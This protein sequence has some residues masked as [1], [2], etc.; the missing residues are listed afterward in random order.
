MPNRPEMSNDSDE[1]RKKALQFKK[2]KERSK[3]PKINFKNITMSDY[4][5]SKEDMIYFKQS[6]EAIFFNKDF[7]SIFDIEKIREFILEIS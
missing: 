2:R 3:E 5:A 7:S 1:S 6:F 4:Q